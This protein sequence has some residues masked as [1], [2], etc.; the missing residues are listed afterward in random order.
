VGPVTS[1]AALPSSP[2]TRRSR[3]TCM[4]I[5]TRWVGGVG[6]GGEEEAGD[7]AS[8]WQKETGRL[9]VDATVFRVEPACRSFSSA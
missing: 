8:E 1:T 3:S 7:G 5:G 6:G 4:G 2:T 9:E